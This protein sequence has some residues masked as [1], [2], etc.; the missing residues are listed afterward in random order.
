MSQFHQTHPAR[1]VRPA[2]VGLESRQENLGHVL[3]RPAEMREKRSNILDLK[4]RLKMLK[5]TPQV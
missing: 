3:G 4:S 1:I 2:V 5:Q